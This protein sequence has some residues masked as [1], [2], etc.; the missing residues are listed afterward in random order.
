M[1]FSPIKLPPVHVPLIFYKSTHIVPHENHRGV[2]SGL[3]V[4]T[5]KMLD[6]GSSPNRTLMR[7]K[8][9]YAS[10]VWSPHTNNDTYKTLRY[11]IES[12]QRRAARWATRD[13]RQT[14]SVTEMLRNLC[15]CQQNQR[16][17]DIRLVIIYEITYDVVAI[18][19]SEHLNPNR[20]GSKFIHPQAYRQMSTSLCTASPQNYH[21]NALPTS[22]VMWQSLFFI[23]F[24]LLLVLVMLSAVWC[25]PINNQ[26]LF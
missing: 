10:S 20:S 1:Q 11:K 9:G 17:I 26:I 18:S 16:R 23:A 22:I 2:C 4:P 3:V 21:W 7:P 25:I 5:S 15:W 8:L 19:V 6:I 13:C 24:L 14:Y 12:A